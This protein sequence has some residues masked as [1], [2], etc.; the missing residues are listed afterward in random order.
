MPAQGQLDEVV[1]AMQNVESALRAN[2]SIINAVAKRAKAIERQRQKGS[3]FRDIF[4]GEDHPL[5][6]EMVTANINRLLEAGATLRRA[7]AKALHEE[8]ATMEEI[9]SLFRVTRQRVST[10]LRDERRLAARAAKAVKKTAKSPAKTTAKAA[11]KTAGATATAKTAAA[12]K[13]ASAGK[14]A[15]AAA[16]TARPATKSAT[17][18]ARTTTAAKTTKAT[19]AAKTSKSAKTA[20]GST[21]ARRRATPASAKATRSATAAKAGGSRKRSTR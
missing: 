19:K 5:V 8:G 4:A 18:A 6:V 21:A 20:G 17:P 14:K 13:V 16:K 15:T 2:S 9:A 7:Q 3:A 11:P 1:R 12:T 10:L